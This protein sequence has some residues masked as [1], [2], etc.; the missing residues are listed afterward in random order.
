MINSICQ[1]YDKYVDCWVRNPR[2]SVRQSYLRLLG[3]VR[4][5]RV[6]D[7]GCGCG[8]DLAE[9]KVLGCYGT[10]LDISEN[11]LQIARKRLG[12]VSKTDLLCEDYFNYTPEQKFDIAVFSMV[13][14]HYPNLDSV[15]KKL[16]QFLKPGGQLLLVTNNP[17]LVLMDYNLP[18][19]QAGKS[20]EYIHKFV[21]N[22]EE[23][24]LKKYL[25]AFSDY[26]NIAKSNGFMVDIFQEQVD[27]SDETSFFNPNPRNDIPNFITFLYRK[28]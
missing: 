24:T 11:S 28:S 4:C 20:V 14:M 25:H 5:K 19:P 2:I 8:F 18:Y 13:V 21:Y 1:F 22:G 10:G 15:F 3:E 27:Y 9:L 23:I 17:Y 7:I 16:A 6:I 26:Y 12:T